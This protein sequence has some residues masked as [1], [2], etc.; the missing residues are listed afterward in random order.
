MGPWSHTARK[1]WR[2]SGPHG[3]IAPRRR[4]RRRRHQPRGIDMF[5]MRTIVRDAAWGLGVVTASSVLVHAQEPPPRPFLRNAIRLD[6]SQLAALERGEAVTKHLP[7]TEK[8]EI[9]VFGAQKL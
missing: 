8:A 4:R 3:I 1:P 9:A 6:D 5:S 7:V 2:R